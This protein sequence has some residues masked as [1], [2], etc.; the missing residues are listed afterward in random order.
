MLEDVVEGLLAGDG[1]TSDVTENL[2]NLTE[3]FG[4]EIGGKG[5]GETGEDMVKSLMS[6]NER[7]VVSAVGDDDGIFSQFRDVSETKDS[8][9]Q[10]VD[11]LTIFGTD[12]QLGSWMQQ[13]ADGCG[14]DS[15]FTGGIS[16][17]ISTR[18]SRAIGT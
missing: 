2:E 16:R 8:V 11:T 10:L 5:R 1:T 14:A 9:F 6:M 4:D 17:A 15:V 12:A 18:F 7:V 13:R 3:I